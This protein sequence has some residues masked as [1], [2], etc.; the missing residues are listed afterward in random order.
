MFYFCNKK[1]MRKKINN[2][3]PSTKWILPGKKFLK[4]TWEKFS[5]IFVKDEWFGNQLVERDKVQ[6]LLVSGPDA[7]RL[8]TFSSRSTAISWQI[9]RS[10]LPVLWQTGCWIASTLPK[11]CDFCPNCLILEQNLARTGR[12]K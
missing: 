6:Q 9:P 10:A 2:S 5:F 12:E 7:H 4:K 8:A 3:F 11:A 1:K